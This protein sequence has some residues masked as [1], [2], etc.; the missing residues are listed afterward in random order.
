[1]LVSYTTAML[2]KMCL[3]VCSGGRNYSSNTCRKT[4][5]KRKYIFFFFNG[6]RDIKIN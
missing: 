6:T 4:K 3:N 5:E 2:S 1:M